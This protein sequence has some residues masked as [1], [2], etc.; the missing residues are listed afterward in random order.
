MLQAAVKC[1]IS[2]TAKSIEQV[3]PKSHQLK[4]LTYT[5][6]R[7]G[8]Q[9]WNPFIVDGCDPLAVDEKISSWHRRSCS[10]GRMASA[11]SHDGIANC[12]QNTERSE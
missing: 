7:G 11:F 10:H 5:L 12:S 4:Q 3:N 2:L 6:F 8:I 9:D 1:G